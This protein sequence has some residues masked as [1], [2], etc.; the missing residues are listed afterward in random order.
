MKIKFSLLVGLLAILF[1]TSCTKE[2]E[3]VFSSEITVEENLIDFDTALDSEN[4]DPEAVQ[5]RSGGYYSFRTLNAALHCTGLN[6]AL[7]SGNKTIYAP[8]DAAFAKL[9]LNRHNICDLDQQ[10]LTE[11]LLYHVVDRKVKLSEQGCVEMID[12]NISQLSVNNHR[13]FINDSRIYYRFNQRG[14]GYNLRVYIIK[15]VL[16]P[17]SNTIVEAAIATDKFSSLVAAVLAAD[18]GIAA[19]LSDPNAIFT[20]FAPT[21]QAFDNLVSA[22][23]ASDLNDLVNTIGVEALST[24]LLYHVVDGCAFSNDLSD[25]QEFTTLQGESISV[26]LSNLSIIDKTGTGSPL[27]ADCLDILTSNGI[28]HTIEKVLLPD[29]ILSTL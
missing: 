20:V 11:I 13:F 27:V 9:G 17:P 7:F 25:G 26:N 29:A 2:S 15:D 5:T 8:S 14:H 23:G 1:F 10:A 3:S 12:G 18:P 6:A 21:N 4:L 24:V 16:T 28:V 22:L 19:A